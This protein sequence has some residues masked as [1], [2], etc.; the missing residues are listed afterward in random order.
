MVTQEIKRTGFIVGG[1]ARESKSARYFDIFN[2]STGEVLGSVRKE[3]HTLTKEEFGKLIERT[4][5]WLSS[6]GIIIP[7]PDSLEASCHR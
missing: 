2:P 1:K 6:F 3:T 7:S 5:A 4:T